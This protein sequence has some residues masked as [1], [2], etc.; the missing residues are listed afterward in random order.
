MIG[1]QPAV[2]GFQGAIM[3]DF[4][5]GWHPPDPQG[6]AGPNHL[7][8]AVN[9]E[10]IV[11]D[12]LGTCISSVTLDSFWGAAGVTFPPGGFSFDPRL[13]YD[14]YGG[15]WLLTSSANESMPQ[16][17]MLV[18]A[19]QTS[20]PTGLWNVCQIPS[21]VGVYPDFPHVG[22]N[23]NWVAIAANMF[24]P[25]DSGTFQYTNLYAVNKATLYGPGPCT[26]QTFGVLSTRTL[27]PA[28]TCDGNVNDLYLMH[29]FDG[30][31]GK[32]NVYKLSGSPGSAT[33]TLVGAT[34]PAQRTWSSGLG[35]NGPQLGGATSIE[36][37]DDS[38]QSVVY[39]NGWLWACQAVKDPS[40]QFVVQWWQTTTSGAVQQF[41]IVSG[42]INDFYSYPSMTVN[43]HNDVFIGYSTFNAGAYA[44]CARSYHGGGEPAGTTRPFNTIV[45]GEASYDLQVR[46]RNRWG[47][48]T[49]TF[50]D[51]VTDDTM[52]TVQEYAESPINNWGTWWKSAAVTG[53][54]AVVSV[55]A[56]DGTV[57]GCA[58]AGGSFNKGTMFKILS[59][60]AFSVQHAFGVAGDGTAPSG[61]TIGSD[62]WIWGTT[63]LGGAY[64]YGTVYRYNASTGVFSII[65]S[66][67]GG[68]DGAY[69]LGGLVE[70]AAGTFYGTTQAGGTS[71]GGIL[72][73]ITATPTYTQ[74]HQFGSVTADGTSPDQ[75]PI[76]GSGGLLWGTTRG[77]GSSTYGTVYN[78]NL[79]TSAY[80]KKHDFTG[81]TTDGRTPNGRL[82]ETPTN[83]FHGVTQ[84]G[85][86]FN[87]G[88]EYALTSAG[89]F[90]LDYSFGNGST[91]GKSP[92][93]I[94]LGTDGYLWGVTNTG[95]GIDVGTVFRIHPTTHAYTKVYTFTQGQDGAN[96]ASLIEDRTSPGSFIG[97]TK[98]SSSNN[99]GC[100]FEVNTVTFT[101]LFSFGY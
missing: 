97:T 92:Q 69:P 83:V 16:A 101:K 22:F 61:V 9:G 66:F 81:T 4:G 82:V 27:T 87:L 63:Q 14:P 36:T 86:A 95:G 32:L 11:F 93:N 24:T 53:N 26:Y 38:V 91:D 70:G 57:F 3:S 73:K 65:K 75:P 44:S 68:A 76:V 41:G 74:L 13:F 1:S 39:R 51:P 98:Y 96:P 30:S 94:V 77:G 56:T 100:A 72:Y 43:K 60:G 28:N 48:Y 15:R 8:E 59:S 34:T 12:R 55:Q 33:Y 89:V 23:K 5:A 2:F 6:A 17:A 67:A 99:T 84:N 35:N 19:S 64:G 54:P 78:F 85:G 80:A 7:A 46:G 71:G 25:G 45:A 49:A 58:T 50:V 10:F 52:W 62:G 29:N 37:A 18:A 31:T 79:S 40:N 42:G 88:V 20:D 90:S 21:D 47:D